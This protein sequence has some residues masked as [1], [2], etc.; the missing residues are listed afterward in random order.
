LFPT[1]NFEQKGHPNV[2]TALN[3]CA[4]AAVANSLDWLK[5]TQGLPITDPD[6][7]GLKGDATKIGKLDT[8]MDRDVTDCLPD[9]D[10]IPVRTAR[11]KGCGVWPLDG[12]LKYISDNKLDLKVHHQGDEFAADKGTIPLD[13]TK[14]I[15]LH[16]VTSRGAGATATWAFICGEL[17]RN[18]DVELDIH[19]DG[20]GRHYVN[21]IGCG[22]I[23][24]VPYIKHISDHAQTDVDPTDELGTDKVDFAFMIGADLIHP[25]PELANWDGTV[26]QVI[27]ESIPNPSALVLVGTGFLGLL[28]AWRLN[29]QARRHAGKRFGLL[30]GSSSARGSPRRST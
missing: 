29:K 5:D 6:G 13:G 15:T 1:F 7:P 26:D 14:D 4:P 8:A 17:Q 27:S 28:L 3:Q 2:Q 16:G 9:P 10:P 12:K 22:M 18:E 30:I 21:V 23:L 19:F 11:Q 24:G 20:G 25:E